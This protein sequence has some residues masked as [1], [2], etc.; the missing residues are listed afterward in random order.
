MLTQLKSL[1][2]N[3]NSQC[4]EYQF[5]KNAYVYDMYPNTQFAYE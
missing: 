5:K 2:E 1:K 4:V 3:L